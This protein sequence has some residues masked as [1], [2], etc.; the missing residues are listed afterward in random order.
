MC[1]DFNEI[2]LAHQLFPMWGFLLE[3]NSWWVAINCAN[4]PQSISIFRGGWCY[5]MLSEWQQSK[6]RGRNG[7]QLLSSKFHRKPV[8]ISKA[9]AQNDNTQLNMTSYIRWLK[10][11]KGK[12]N[13]KEVKEW[14]N[15]ADKINGKYVRIATKTWNEIIVRDNLSKAGE[16]INKTNV[17]WILCC[18]WHSSSSLYLVCHKRW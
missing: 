16:L 4:K 18:H 12:R 3:R 8:V 11:R 5:S 6:K 15:S 7:P 14:W 17:H 2:Y 10:E 13:Q 1:Q 9:H